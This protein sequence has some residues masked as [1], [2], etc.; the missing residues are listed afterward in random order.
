MGSG[1]DSF[2]DSCAEI[3]EIEI[4]E[5]EGGVNVNLGASSKG[6]GKSEWDR[7]GEAEGTGMDTEEI[8]DA[9]SRLGS[10][11]MSA[12]EDMNEV[13]GGREGGMGKVMSPG[14]ATASAHEEI[15]NIGKFG[16]VHSGSGMLT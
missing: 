7:V 6:A 15:G 13:V 4:K 11:T 14:S 12:H 2:T 3:D 10:G 16:G 8:E 5:E 1:S 9:D